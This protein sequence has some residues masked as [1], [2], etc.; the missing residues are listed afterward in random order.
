MN[1]RGTNVARQSSIPVS[2]NNCDTMSRGTSSTGATLRRVSTTLSN[3]TLRRGHCRPAHASPHLASAKV[4][5]SFRGA[6]RLARCS[7]HYNTEP[8]IHAAG[9]VS[10]ARP[11]GFQY[12]RRWSTYANACRSFGGLVSSDLLPSS[13][14]CGISH[15][16][17]KGSASRPHLSCSSFPEPVQNI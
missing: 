17:E 8:T 16:A 2:V 12:E 1:A 13:N 7:H 11:S 9:T 14:L 6:R 15:D 4:R 10:L 5:N 3:R